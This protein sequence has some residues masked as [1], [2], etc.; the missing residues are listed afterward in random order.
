MDR[1]ILC[2]TDSKSRL[3][4]N[5]VEFL[6]KRMDLSVYRKKVFYALGKR[7]GVE[8]VETEALE[9]L[10]L[11]KSILCVRKRANLKRLQGISRDTIVIVPSSCR[12]LL[13]T[14]SRFSVSVVTVGMSSKDAITFSS[15]EGEEW[16]VSLQRSLL[17]LKGE[18]V[19]PM[20]IPVSLAGWKDEEEI[21]S[22]AAILMLL[23]QTDQVERLK[24]A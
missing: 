20:E 1:V 13:E 12:R 9:H 14:I 4:E 3:T 10:W 11:G 7:P 21:L 24:L 16:V 23:G 8:L 18:V 2:G 19:E 17:N 22:F 5:L 15:H 6:K